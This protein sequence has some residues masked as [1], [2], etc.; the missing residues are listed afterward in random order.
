MD[1][2]AWNDPAELRVRLDVALEH[3][4]ALAAEI[5]ELRGRLR[6]AES[7]LMPTPPFGVRAETTYT[8][9]NVGAIQVIHP[10][11]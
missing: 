7:A 6:V 5:A 2:W 1:E 11:A 10:A 4:A 8:R 3:S 9:R